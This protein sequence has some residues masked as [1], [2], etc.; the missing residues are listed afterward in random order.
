MD[1]EMEEQVELALGAE[2]ES[3]P[4]SQL[5]GCLKYMK[6]E[7]D[8][9]K[10]AIKDTIMMIDKVFEDTGYAIDVEDQIKIRLERVLNSK[11]KG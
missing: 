7:R 11:N 2:Y 1:T 10:D 5:R 9:M 3:A 4:E 6:G 8:R